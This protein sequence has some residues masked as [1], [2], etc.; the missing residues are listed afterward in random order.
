MFASTVLSI[1]LRRDE[2]VQDVDAALML[3][4]ANG[5]HAAYRLLV[6][7]YLRH[8]VTMAYRVLFD[9]ADAE[10]VAQE[11]FC[12]SGSMPRA[13]VPMAVPASR[14]GSIAWW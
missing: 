1:P 7:R 9:R 2:S 6:D 5:D 10:E 3:R 12:G 8:A 4:V 11:A 13:G 14:P